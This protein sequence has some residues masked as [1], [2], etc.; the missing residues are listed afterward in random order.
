MVPT[1]FSKI[2]PFERKGEGPE[3]LRVRLNDSETVLMGTFNAA[4]L[5]HSR[6]L[7]RLDKTNGIPIGRA[8]KERI[9]YEG[10]TKKM[11]GLKYTCDYLVY[12]A[13]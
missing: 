13:R 10:R 1:Q 3:S 8:K 11:E 4:E 6:I 7:S 9:L 2:S 12:Y 5:D